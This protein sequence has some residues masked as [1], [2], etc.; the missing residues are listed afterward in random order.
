MKLTKASF[1]LA[2]RPLAVCRTALAASALGLLGAAP[3]LAQM[4]PYLGQIA[5][6]GFNFCP[7]DWARADGALLPIA[8][9]QALFSLLGTTYGGDGRTTFGLPDLRGR[10]VVGTGQGPGL[11]SIGQG[12]RGGQAQVTLTPAQ[13]PQHSHALVA[14]TAPATHAAPDGRLLAATQNAGAYAAAGGA[15]ATLAPTSVAPQGGSQP[16]SVRDPYLGMTACIAVWGAFPPR[17]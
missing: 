7:R 5:V 13:M 14:S 4:E 10:T 9:Y 6:F 12:D 11:L 17:D 3:A 1:P 8:Q 16:F 15:T 2:R